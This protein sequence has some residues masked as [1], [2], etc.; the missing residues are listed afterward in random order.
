MSVCAIPIYLSQ[1]N[2]RYPDLSLHLNAY[3]WGI[4]IEMGRARNYGQ[5][6]QTPVIT[7]RQ[8]TIKLIVNN[9]CYRA[10]RN[11]ADRDRHC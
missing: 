8:K 2:D 5:I 9:P 10:R 1:I 4:P 6:T 7:A 3:E 11:S